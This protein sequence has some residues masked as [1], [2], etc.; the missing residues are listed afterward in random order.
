MTANSVLKI[1]DDANIECNDFDELPDVDIL[2]AYIMKSSDINASFCPMI[3]DHKLGS[4]RGRENAYEAFRY[5][6]GRDNPE[7]L[8]KLMMSLE[9]NVHEIWGKRKWTRD[10]CFFTFGDGS[11]NTKVQLTKQT[12]LRVT[13]AVSDALKPFEARSPLRHNETVDILFWRNL[14][15]AREESTASSVRISLKTASYN[16][17]NKKFAGN[18]S[19]FQFELKRA[20][21][22]HHCDLVVAV[23]FSL[24]NKNK[25]V[26]AY[27]FD[28]TEVYK[29]D[30][31]KFCWNKSAYG[32]KKFNMTND[33]GRQGMRD[34]VSSFM[35]TDKERRGPVKK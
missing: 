7:K 30:R 25:V 34:Y 12:E 1:R 27:V 29:V 31:Q 19:G 9:S 17:L 20:P 15:L 35:K 26:A 24:E 2:E 33:V 28:T 10:D 13:K 21:N 11:P 3:Y 4:K 32:N 6:V 22:A 8:D 23:Q 5:V 18:Y 14:D 16:N